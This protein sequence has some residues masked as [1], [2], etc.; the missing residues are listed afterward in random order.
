MSEHLWLIITGTPAPQGSK[1]RTRYG[2]YDDNAKVLKPWREAVTTQARSTRPVA[3]GGPLAVDLT[4][5]LPRPKGHYRTGR[6]AHLLRD[7]AP[8]YP[9]GAQVGDVDKLARAVFDG[10][11]D[12]GVWHDDVQVVTLTAR[13]MYPAAGRFEQP[14]AVIGIS[15]LGGAA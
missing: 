1:T 6:N 7:G 10:L 15:P 8:V 2:M 3:M 5:I 11:T 4:V 12:A 13:K 14:G 9:V